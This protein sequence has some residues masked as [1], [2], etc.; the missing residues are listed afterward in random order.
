MSHLDCVKSRTFLTERV[1]VRWGG[2]GG[3]E[4]G[5]VERRRMVRDVGCD[6]HGNFKGTVYQMHA[7]TKI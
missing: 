2:G 6:P 4:K 1:R 5:E 7:L 3:E